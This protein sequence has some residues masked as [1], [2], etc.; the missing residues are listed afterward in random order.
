MN[1]P[2]TCTYIVQVKLQSFM[3]SLNLCMKSYN[4]E[5]SLSKRSYLPPMICAWL[6]ALFFESILSDIMIS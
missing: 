4:K 2:S 6:S 5:H 3:T 1:I